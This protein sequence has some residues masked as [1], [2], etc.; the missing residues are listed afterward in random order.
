MDVN[1]EKNTR[2]RAEPRFVS[3]EIRSILDRVC[4]ECGD[5]DIADSIY[6]SPTFISHMRRV[7]ERGGVVYTDT[8]VLLNEIRK[9]I[10]EDCGVEVQCLIDDKAVGLAAQQ[11]HVTR[12]EVAVDKAL[13]VQDPLVYIIASAPA[14]LRAVL[15][16][17]RSEAL[18][19]LCVIAAFT[20]FAGAVQIKE[21]LLE[22]GVSCI[23]VRG[24]KGNLKIASSLFIN[25]MREICT[26]S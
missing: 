22:S 2:H 10:P 17:K 15:R 25:A 23:A 9:A 14:A 13:S 16:H 7:F 6:I 11:R 18:T 12:A 5:P 26:A 4:G 8:Q 19:D 21:A 24:K 20:G 3:A 1:R